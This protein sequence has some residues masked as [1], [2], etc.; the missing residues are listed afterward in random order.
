MKKY[1]FL[2]MLFSGLLF[3]AACEKGKTPVQPPVT[4]EKK[5]ITLS[6]N[7]EWNGQ[8]L[9]LSKMQYTQPNGEVLMFRTWS[10]ILAKLSLVR[11]D[12][13]EEL[14]GDGYQW[15]NL[16]TGRTQFNYATAP[17]GNYK[18][19]RFQLGPDSAINHGDPNIWP[20]SHPLNS[21]LTG[22]HWGWAGGYIFQAIDGE[23]K[24]NASAG[25]TSGLS[26]H[27]A[28]D[29]FQ[30]TYFLPFNFSLDTKH[31]TANI[32]M[33]AAIMFSQPNAIVLKN[34]S[35]SHSSGPA[36]VALM[37]KIIENSKGAYR[38][39]SVN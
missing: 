36:E 26:F 27:T 14:L 4:P 7:A 33:D 12:N 8:P 13:T 3:L 6:F 29:L 5:G 21:N 39:V 19:I 20:A 11:E 15:I 28:T 24:D 30:T 16:A 1:S 18:G 9:E 23:Y 10:T 2:F 17:A 37:Q 22:L 31:K 35:V 34:K 25:S 38:I 32:A